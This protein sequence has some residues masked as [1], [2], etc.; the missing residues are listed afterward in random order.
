MRLSPLIAI[1]GALLLGA[2]LAAQQTS[3]QKIEAA[4]QLLEAGKFD[5]ATVILKQVIEQDPAQRLPAYVWLG[6][7]NH[8]AGRDSLARAA[9]R[10]A[11]TLDP[12]LQLQGVGE[13]DP[14]RLPRL[15]AE[16]QAAAKGEPA[17]ATPASAGDTAAAPASDPLAPAAAAPSGRPDIPQARCLPGCVG[18]DRPP[19]FVSLPRVAFP[20]HLRD[21]ARNLDLVVRCIVDVDG[22][23]EPKSVEIVRSNVASMG[24]DI[25]NGVSHARF[26]P[27]RTAAGPTRVL[28][29]LTFTIR[30]QG[31][32]RS[33]AN[34]VLGA[35]RPL[36]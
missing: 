30:S 2:P 33:G 15:L 23:V 4:R 34:Y 16:E 27:G 5:S 21:A 31:G 13:L 19:E 8:F 12:G 14:A 17:P 9:F 3:E 18:V 22:K 1:A 6:I 25:I 7:V 20:D 28:V 29:E 11:Y 32:T 24:A 26:R 36:R 35:P 10:Q